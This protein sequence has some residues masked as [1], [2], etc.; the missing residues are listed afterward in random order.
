[1]CQPSS[2]AGPTKPPAADDKAVHPRVEYEDKATSLGKAKGVIYILSL[3]A[4][5]LSVSYLVIVPTVVLV[6]FVSPKLAQHVYRVCLG[7]F[8][9]YSSGVLEYACG[10]E[11]VVT[12]EDGETLDFKDTDRVLLISNH[13]TEIDWLLHWNFA[14]KI[15]CHDRIMTMLKAP[16]KMV[17]IFGGILHFFGF[18]FV[19]R[20]WSEDEAKLSQTMDAYRARPFGAWLAMFPEGTALYDKTLASSHAFQTARGK[21]VTEYVL[22]PRVKGFELCVDKFQPDYVL[23]MTMA[24][25]ELREGIRPSPLRL[26]VGQFPTAV[27]FHVRKFALADIDN[28]K[29]WLEARFAAKEELLSTFYKSPAPQS[30]AKPVIALPNSKA[31]F[32]SSIAVIV[33]STTA[34]SLVL[35]SWPYVGT[36]YLLIVLVL[37]VAAARS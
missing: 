32:Y 1:M 16:L 25:P 5:A 27:H 2:H 4:A 15:H 8:C 6:A 30:F 7:L 10:M 35:S 20:N 9:A 31:P 23:D 22:A 36:T 26:L 19:Q 18:P 17:P 3:F 28:P 21:P 24:Y 12:G 33:A 11:V 34:F 29:E 14:T 37:L 13:R